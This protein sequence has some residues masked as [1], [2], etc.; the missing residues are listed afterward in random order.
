VNPSFSQKLTLDAER[1]PPSGVLLVDKSPGVSSQAVVTRVKRLL[2]AAKGGHTGTLDPLAS[3]L[4]P[5]CLGEATKFAHLLLEAEK[6]YQAVIRLGV[7]TATG[8]REGATVAVSPVAVD[9]TQVEGVLARFVGEIDQVP[10][11]F[12]AIK[13]HGQPLYRFARE[14]IVLPRLARRIRIRC[15]ELLELDRDLL[16]ISVTCGKGTYIRTLAEDIGLALGCGACL[17]SLRRTA[18]GNFTLSTSITLDVLEGLTASERGRRLLAVDSPVA[19]LPRIDVDSTQAR[20]LV[21]GRSFQSEHGAG[22]G[23]VRLYDAS[24]GRFLGVG[25]RT[26]VREIAP[27][28][29]MSGLHE[30]MNA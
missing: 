24:S 10:P 27:R 30:A 21:H 5:V 14:G 17:E 18:V 15:L 16:H 4:L 2:G 11:M 1:C 20:C 22:V 26:G 23:L 29:L 12:S 9:R 13:Y 25:A 8:D 7:T 3:G 28:R 6:S 19:S